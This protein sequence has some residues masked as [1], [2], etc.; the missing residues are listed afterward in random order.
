MTCPKCG[1]DNFGYYKA[2]DGL[3]YY[4]QCGCPIPTIRQ[5]AAA[6]GMNSEV[7]SAPMC[8]TDHK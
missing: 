4:T 3:Y 7:E 8:P 6:K 5:I 1:T 2:A